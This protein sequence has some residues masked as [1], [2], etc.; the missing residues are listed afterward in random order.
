MNIKD[1]RIGQKIRAPNGYEARI[2][3][4]QKRGRVF[5]DFGPGCYHYVPFQAGD[6]TPVSDP[7]QSCEMAPVITDQCKQI[8]ELMQSRD[9]WKATAQQNCR[10]AFYWREELNKLQKEALAE[11]GLVDPGHVFGD[12]KEHIHPAIHIEDFRKRPLAEVAKIYVMPSIE[13]QLAELAKFSWGPEKL[14]I[15]DDAKIVCEL[16]E[17]SGPMTSREIADRL[18]LLEMCVLENLIEAREAGVVQLVDGKY[19]IV[20]D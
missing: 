9:A 16:L 4:I 17:G 11:G 10:N 18:Y 8:A 14:P 3:E 2:V 19:Q 12:S 20:R 15:S 6:L 7:C 5:V 1:C 13:N